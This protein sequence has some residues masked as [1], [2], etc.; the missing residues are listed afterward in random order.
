MLDALF[1]YVHGELPYRSLQFVYE[2]HQ[3]EFYQP[4]T[5]VNYPNEELYTRITEFKNII[6]V[7]SDYTVIVKEYPQDFDR[8]DP[9]KTCLTTL[10]LMQKI[11]RRTE[12]ISDWPSDF[13]T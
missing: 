7:V 13:P 10:S 11:W 8:Q 1:D 5:T 3:T 12:F 4:A 9:L 2:R 6:P